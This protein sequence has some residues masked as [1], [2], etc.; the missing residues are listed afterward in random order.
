M[1]AILKLFDFIPSW[2]LG[3]LLALALVIAGVEHTRRLTAYERL[4]TVQAQIAT[5]RANAA[6]AARKAEQEARAEENRRQAA[7]RKV[8][9]DA[10]AQAESARADAVA[11]GAAA[12]SLRQRVAALVA[13]ARRGVGNS[14]PGE[15]SKGEPD[16][17]ALDLLA[18]VFQRADSTSGELAT[19]ADRLRIAGQA[20]ERQYDALT[21][22]AG[23]AL[24][25]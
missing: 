21:A 16:S 19:Y 3:V 9:D 22:P 12:D 25:K 10:Q 2:L 5:E 4:A 11:A 20:C 23:V 13:S 6:E 1:T 8:I 18:D 15:R 7:T 17:A 14:A 24:F